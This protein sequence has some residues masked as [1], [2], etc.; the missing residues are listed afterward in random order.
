VTAIVWVLIA[1][2]AVALVAP[3]T[4]VRVVAQYERG[5]VFRF[6]RVLPVSPMDSGAATTG[7]PR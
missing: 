5:V 4:S 7:A 1:T 2:V 3:R 6:G